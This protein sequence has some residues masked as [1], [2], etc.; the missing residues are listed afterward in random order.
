MHSYDVDLKSI[1]INS[2]HSYDTR[3]GFIVS[4]FIDDYVGYGEVAPL[5]FFSQENL[6]QA[7]WKFEELRASLHE[8]SF[9]EKEELLDLFYLIAKDIPSLNFAIDIALLDVMS[10]S[11]KMPLSKYLNSNALNKIR[12][13][14]FYFKDKKNN[15]KVVKVKLGKTSLNDDIKYFEFI[16]NHLSKDT[17]FRIDLNQSYTL[18]NLVS[19]L[20]HFK[21][22]K[23]QYIEEPFQ[24]PTINDI[25][26]IKSLT[27][28]S[29]AL[30]ETI[31]SKNYNELISSGLID[32]AILKAPLFGSVKNIFNF[33]K[34]LDQYNTKLILSSSL[35]TP[36]GNMSSIHIAAALELK[37]FHGLNFFNFFDYENAL[38]YDSEDD[39]VS[40][41]HL[42]GIG[43]KDAIR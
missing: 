22:S 31:I 27:N 13:S 24:R 42:V 28:F 15:S 34:Y 7:I 33:K 3:S 14:D 36:I 5:N 1:L 21:N 35:Q 30:D 32:Y 16:I 25:K 8:G 9:Y 39:V 12:F 20:N 17:I 19:L 41:N 23:I 43:V 29:I 37:E 6:K 26:V 4:L 38:P 11:K 2:K 40:L 10:K 18:D